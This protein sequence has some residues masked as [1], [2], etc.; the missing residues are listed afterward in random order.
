MASRLP[1]GGEPAFD[2]RPQF[3]PESRTLLGNGFD[4]EKVHRRPG[5]DHGSVGAEAEGFLQC[6]GVAIDVEILGDFDD[7]D[8]IP[9]IEGVGLVDA[10]GS[11]CLG[12][13]I[14]LDFHDFVFFA[15]AHSQ[16]IARLTAGRLCVTVSQ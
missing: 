5:D 4:A 9:L 15:V 16:E 14:G 12:S 7:E 1:S 10:K 11:E 3:G 13:V 2:A 6:R 8:V